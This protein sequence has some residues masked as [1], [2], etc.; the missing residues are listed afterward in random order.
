VN[1]TAEAY[2][3]AKRPDVLPAPTYQLKSNRIPVS[4]EAHTGGE[5]EAR[6]Q[7]SRSIRRV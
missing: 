3:N 5:I 2:V 4:E 1:V 6:S 7:I